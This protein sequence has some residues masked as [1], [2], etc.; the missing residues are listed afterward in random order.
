MGRTVIDAAWIRFCSWNPRFQK[1]LLVTCSGNWAVIV[2]NQPKS[3]RPQVWKHSIYISR[4]AII[5][6]RELDRLYA[7]GYLISVKLSRLTRATRLHTPD[8]PIAIC[9]WGTGLFSLR[10]MHS[11][12]QRP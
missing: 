12:S 6:T 4:V 3:Y 11:Q 2:R 7:R 5:G 1:K 10:R 8:L 9:R